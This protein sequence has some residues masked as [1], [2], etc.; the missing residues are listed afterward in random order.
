MF[1]TVVSNSGS[2]L[3]AKLA[4]QTSLSKPTRTV[5]PSVNLLILSQEANLSFVSCLFHVPLYFLNKNTVHFDLAT[6]GHVTSYIITVIYTFDT[7]Q[8][9]SCH[10][11]KE[12][13]KVISYTVFHVSWQSS[14]R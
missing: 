2:L 4:S 6:T 12:K 13:F 8:L 3:H 10:F 9:S 11:S 7:S 5:C 1:L 14:F